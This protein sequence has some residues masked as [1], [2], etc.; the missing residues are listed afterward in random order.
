MRG[1]FI[2]LVACMVSLVIV[3][4]G[5]TE[6]PTPQEAVTPRPPA[7]TPTTP[8]TPTAV[9]EPTE[10]PVPMAIVTADALNLRVGPGTEYDRLGLVRLDDELRVTGR[11]EDG[12]WI[13]VVAPG[14]INAWV[15]VEYTRMNTEVE[16]LP[17]AEMPE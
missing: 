2:L 11:N 7:L 3:G 14:G 6:T 10:T 5:S 12:D 8:P 1:T 15:A 13:S 16:S 17:L 4:C 9:P